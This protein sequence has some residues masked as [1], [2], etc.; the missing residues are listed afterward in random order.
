MV[1]EVWL[2]KKKVKPD[3]D[4]YDV[5]KTYTNKAI[6]DYSVPTG[7]ISENYGDKSDYYDVVIS[8][9]NDTDVSKTSTVVAVKYDEGYQVIE[10]ADATGKISS[11]IKANT[12]EYLQK[13]AFVDPNLYGNAHVEDYD[14]YVLDT[15]FY[16][17]YNG[18]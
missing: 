3:N 15:E 6:T 8:N 18:D 14:V 16:K 2:D 12:P 11:R 1:A 5:V 17:S 7:Y 10:E 13:K 4:T 9:P